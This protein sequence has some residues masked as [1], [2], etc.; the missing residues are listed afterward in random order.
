MQVQRRCKNGKTPIWDAI[1]YSTLDMTFK[2]RISGTRLFPSVAVVSHLNFSRACATVTFSRSHWKYP[3]TS[4]GTR[5]QWTTSD[6]RPTKCCFNRVEPP[7][8]SVCYNSCIKIRGTNFNNVAMQHLSL[9]MSR[10]LSTCISGQHKQINHINNMYL[11]YIC[12][13]S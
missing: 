8:L 4:G 10:T 12:T 9:Y 11:N 5:L 6:P 2:P 3:R 13:K 1:W 7:P